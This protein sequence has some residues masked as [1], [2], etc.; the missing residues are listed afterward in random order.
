MPSSFA[1]NVG[2]PRLSLIRVFMKKLFSG[3]AGF[4]PDHSAPLT[5]PGTR[6]H[7]FFV[8][9]PRSSIGLPLMGHFMRG[10]V[11]IFFHTLSRTKFLIPPRA[12]SLNVMSSAYK[13]Q[14][15]F[16]SFFLFGEG[17]LSLSEVNMHGFGRQLL[18]VAL[19]ICSLSFVVGS[20]FVVAENHSMSK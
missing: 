4:L 11:I 6:Q 16:H 20:S 19:R 12:L 10:C 8:Y 17:R 1:E 9:T 3:S 14:L 18:I 7:R 15:F 5:E 2:L 13:C